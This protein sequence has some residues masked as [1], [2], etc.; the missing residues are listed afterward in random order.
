MC[1][2]CWRPEWAPMKTRWRSSRE[3]MQV[4]CLNHYWKSKCCYQHQTD[5][6]VTMLCD[7]KAVCQWGKYF[8][9]KRRSYISQR[10]HI[11]DVFNMHI[12]HIYTDWPRVAFSVGLTDAGSVGPFDT[13]IALKFSKVFTNISQAYNPTTGIQLFYIQFSVLMWGEVLTPHWFSPLMQVSSQ[14][15]SEEPTTS[16]SAGGTC[17]VQI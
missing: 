10:L 2:Q 7:W 8:T 17:V 14:P 4:S 16:D 1:S 3:R 6:S 12:F 13:E 15:Q 11:S 9:N 5:C